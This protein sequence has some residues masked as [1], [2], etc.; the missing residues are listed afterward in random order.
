MK[1]I[2]KDDIV[3]KDQIEHTKTE[4]MILE[5]VNHPYLVGLAYAFQTSNKLYFI[6]HFM[7]GG[8]LFQ[9]L[10][11]AKRFPEKQ[12]KFYAMQIALGLGYLHS[13][14][15][16]YRDLKL[17]NVLMDDHGNV[18]LTDFGMAKIVRDGQIAKTFCGTP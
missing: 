10:S 13:K 8:Q 2:N 12:A 15:F 17:E 6:M 18:C 14:D 9:H 7:R 5:H 1:S 16:I 4:K 11:N 3:K